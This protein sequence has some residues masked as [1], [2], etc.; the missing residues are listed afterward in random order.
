MIIELEKI[1]IS[2]F[3]ELVE[4]YLKLPPIENK[5]E[6]VVPCI[7]KLIEYGVFTEDELR[8][9]LQKNHISLHEKYFKMTEE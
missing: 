4:K 7:E 2:R 1:A 5:R 3:I 6:L 9:E 8:L